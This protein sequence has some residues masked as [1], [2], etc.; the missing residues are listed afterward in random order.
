LPLKILK[1]S[2]VIVALFCYAKA[3]PQG[4][5]SKVNTRL[6]TEQKSVIMPADSA[7]QRDM[8]DVIN[9]LLHKG[10]SP[11]S[12]KS[13]RRL[14]FSGV[15]SL[16]YTLSTGFAVDLTGNVAF[17]TGSDHHENLS[18]IQTDLTYD[19][20]SQRL[21]FTRAE[22]WFPDNEYRLVTDIRWL[23]FPTETYGLGILTTPAQTNEIDYNYVRLY[24][25]LYKTL[26]TDFYIGAGYNFDYYYN[27]AAGGNLDKSVSDFEKYGQP[28]T[29]TSSGI[30]LDLL[31]DSRRNSI[32]PL[33]GEYANLVYRQNLTLLGSNS[34]WQ[35]I[36]LDLRKYLR[37]SDHSNNVLAFWSIIWLSSASTPYLAL[38]QTAGDMYTNSGRGYAEGRF[39]GRDMLYLET[40]YRFGISRN[41]LFGGVVFA[42]GQSFTDYPGNT[43]KGVAPGTGAGIR[44]KINKHSDT[45][46]CIDYGVGTNGSHGFFVNLGEVF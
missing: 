34:N 24:G 12:R 42:N 31:F 16:G 18:N 17:Y 10:S 43:F 6:A 11:D 5:T 40:E 37:L 27:I 35:S 41:G 22:V 20:K 1:I 2:I 4:D 14:N 36:E 44:I 32:N 21:F 23:K 13:A 30:N 46:V 39:R 25:T 15:P 7:G 19:T 26:V 33:G 38:P 8:I 3:F 9:R 29:S 28:T 45:N